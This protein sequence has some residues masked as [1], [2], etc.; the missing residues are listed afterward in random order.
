MAVSNTNMSP[1][2]VSEIFVSNLNTSLKRIVAA[3]MK[4][5]K[6]CYFGSLVFCFEINNWKEKVDIWHCSLYVVFLIFVLPSHQKYSCVSYLHWWQP[7][8]CMD[9]AD[10]S[11]GKEFLCN[12]GDKG[13]VDSPPEL[14]KSPGEGNDNPLQYSC[15]KNPMD[16]GAWWATVY[17]V[18]ENWTWLK[19]LSTQAT[20]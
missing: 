15:L 14:G 1:T 13:D 5:T 17:G 10:G 12:A 4:L 16:R 11:A 20:V 19:W 7:S 3:H 2:Y 8:H 18:A 6:F 9:F